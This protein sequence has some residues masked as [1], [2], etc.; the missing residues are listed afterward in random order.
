VNYLSAY[1]FPGDDI[2]ICPGS[3][4]QAIEAITANPEYKN[5]VIT[6]GLIK[7]ML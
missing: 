6:H 1:D 5:V 4:L 7:F 3:A 2:P